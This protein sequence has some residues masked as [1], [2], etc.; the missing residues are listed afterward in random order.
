MDTIKETINIAGRVLIVEPKKALEI[1]QLI[2]ARLKRD[3]RISDELR[4][5]NLLPSGF[6]NQ[7]ARWSNANYSSNDSIDKRAYQ[8]KRG[9]VIETRFPDSLRREWTV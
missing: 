2:A 9:I 1:R 5:G 4:Q 6:R 3:A 8:S 7:T